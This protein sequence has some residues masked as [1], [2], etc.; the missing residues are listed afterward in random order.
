M[1]NE[2]TFTLNYLN[3][4][5]CLLLTNFHLDAYHTVYSTLEFVLQGF[6]IQYVFLFKARAAIDNNNN[7]ET[8][9]LYY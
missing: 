8:Q 9:K 2:V 1:Q 7:N 5:V 4:I 6:D 3:N